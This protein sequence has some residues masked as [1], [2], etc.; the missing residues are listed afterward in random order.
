MPT[1]SDRKFA[2]KRFNEHV[3]ALWGIANGLALALIV[4][5]VVTAYIGKDAPQEM[6]ADR[7]QWA[8]IGV[9]LHVVGHVIIALFM[10]KED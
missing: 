5:A 2:A 9:L 10:Q 7:I 1:G 4:A 6:D 8:C 3:K